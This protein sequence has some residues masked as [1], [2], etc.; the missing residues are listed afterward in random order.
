MSVIILC[1]YCFHEIKVTDTKRYDEEN[2]K[3]YHKKCFARSAIVRQ[4]NPSKAAADKEV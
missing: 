1:D 2:R 3:V 4:H